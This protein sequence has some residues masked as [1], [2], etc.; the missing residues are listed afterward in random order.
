MKLLTVI[1][2]FRTP[3]LTLQAI[4][5]AE[6]AMAKWSDARIDVVDNDSQ[7]GSF[8]AI[9]AGIAG[10]DPARVRLLASPRNGGFGAGNNHA[11]RAALAEDD[12]PELIYV[13]NSD[14]FPAEDA[15]DALVDFLDAHPSA[16]FA[17]SYIHGTDGRPHETA[18]RFP[19][20]WSEIE[21]GLGLGIV[22]R[23]LEKHR[24]PILPMPTTTCEVDWLA[25]ASLMM[26]AS[27]LREIGLFDE[28]FFLYFEE[29]DLCRR[30]KR[31][32]HT[33]WYVVE[34]R[35]AHVGSASTGMKRW[36]R[37]PTY[38]LDSRAYYF[39]KNHGTTYLRV[40]NAV[41][42]AAIG[43]FRVRRRLQGKPDPS[44]P[45]YFGDFV[46]YNLLGDRGRGR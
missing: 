2:N 9:R 36:R 43:A 45:G 6:R 33:T 30:A 26:R 34:S 20:V 1:L 17:G 44:P 29:T 15:I 5:A 24:V 22:S 41:S 31:A 38:W 42:A 35:V 8:D 12:P 25:G 3:E 27:V 18:F 37:I 13:L 11:I 46:R 7:D 39:E 21:S 4:A 40:A 23:L 28:T 10:Y 32:G 16:G 19:T 14:A